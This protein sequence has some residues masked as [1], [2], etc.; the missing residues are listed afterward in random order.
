[1]D[2][3][4]AI[5]NGVTNSNTIMQILDLSPTEYY[6]RTSRLY[7]IGVVSR[8][9]GE[10]ILTPFGRLVY[11]A[12]LKISAAFSR[13]SELRMVDAV[14]S[15]SDIPGNKQKIIFDKLIGDA[16]LKAFN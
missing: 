8:G 9:K 3:I 1:V 12:Q 15:H 6:S 16:E 10:I 5:W 2:I 11:K 13:A 4:T 14:K 7:V